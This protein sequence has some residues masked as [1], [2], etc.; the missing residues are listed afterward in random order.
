MSD[1][2]T[3]NEDG[4]PGVAP[5]DEAPSE[6]R[7]RILVCIDGTDEALKALQYAVRIGSGTDADMTLL[8]VRPVDQ[9]L[10]SGGLQISV[11]RENMLDWGLELPG[12]KALKAARDK[13]VDLGWLNE[14]W[15]KEFSNVSV[16]GDM[17]GD[18][19]TVYTS[20]EGRSIAMK[21]LVAPTI[22][23]GILGEAEARNY[24]I[25]ILAKS[26][27][28][29]PTGL[30][31]I[32]PAVADE[33]AGTH[34]DTVLVTKML[35]ESHGHLICVT[36]NEA[37]IDAARHDAEIASRCACPVYLFSVAEA[38]ED[39][40]EA[41][42]AIA[43]AKAAL[44]ELGINSSGEKTAVG[45]PVTEIIEEGRNYSVIVMARSSKRTGWLRFLKSS[46]VSKVLAG[47]HNSVM[48]AR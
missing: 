8:Y 41:E 10:R 9:G 40:P 47:A 12:T 5:S 3:T 6:K 20:E 27:S 19:I 7:F 44:A 25:T 28:D 11:A 32:E 23:Q 16:A 15:E 38:E 33:I 22:A 46:V 37:S 39:L 35:E 18:N 1:S 4:M 30:G 29:G 17:L 42:K 26:E 13:L 36:N 2:D 14:D 48:I 45:D 21:L 24:D 34:T 31:Y 43:A